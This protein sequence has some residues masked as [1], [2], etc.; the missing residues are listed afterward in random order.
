M[1]VAFVFISADGQPLAAGRSPDRGPL[2][3]GL[4]ATLAAAPD[5]AAI[6][7]AV[8][9]FTQALHALMTPSNP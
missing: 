6:D 9:S 3:M 1:M 7:A 8:T 2:R 5:E 4:G